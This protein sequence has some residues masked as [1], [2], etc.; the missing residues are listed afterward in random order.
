MEDNSL[1]Y[2]RNRCTGGKIHSHFV[3]KGKQHKNNESKDR[4]RKTRPKENKRNTLPTINNTVLAPLNYGTRPQKKPNN[5]SLDQNVQGT[6]WI[7]REKNV[8][9]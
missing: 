3:K 9:M 5:V 7:V 4:K 1:K 2:S 8:A 6:S